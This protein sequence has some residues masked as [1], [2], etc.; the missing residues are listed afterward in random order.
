MRPTWEE[1]MMHLAMVARSRATCER[2]KVGCVITT[3]DNYVVSTGYNGSPPEM[4]HCDDAGHRMLGGSCV[5]TVHA[6]Q[7]AIAQ[8]S[9]RGVSTAG[10]VAY[11][12][13]HPCI[14]CAKQLASA[15]I[16]VVVFLKGYRREYDEIAREVSGIIFRE[17]VGRSVWES[18]LSD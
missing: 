9:K 17:Y 4:D 6:E 12:T 5:R 2:L 13:H 3:P 14:N 1:Y 15:G 10:C 8:A 18:S 11:V 7:N 16:R